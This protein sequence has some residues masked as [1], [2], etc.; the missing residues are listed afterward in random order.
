[1]ESVG[2]ATKR[3]ME[4]VWVSVM[5]AW[6]ATIYTIFAFLPSDINECE[7][8][9]HPCDAERETCQNLIGSHVCRCKDGLVKVK[10]MCIEVE[11]NPTPTKPTEK[12][13]KKKKKPKSKKGNELE[14][15]LDRRE[16]PWYYTLGPL[17]LLFVTQKYVRPNLVTAAGLVLV[18]ALVAVIHPD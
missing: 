15:D 4:C 11:S 5:S 16:Y 18:L 8:A 12:P 7:Q 9:T 14:D 17:A 3:K 2:K 10:G 1:M 6:F 13:K